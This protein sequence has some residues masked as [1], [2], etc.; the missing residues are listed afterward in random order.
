MSLL[1]DLLTIE[2]STSTLDMSPSLTVEAR[3]HKSV[4]RAIFRSPNLA[5][6]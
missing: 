6:S 1:N 2:P 4:D 5:K 3:S